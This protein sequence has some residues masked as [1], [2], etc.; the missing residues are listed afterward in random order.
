MIFARLLEVEAKLNGK[1][2][3]LDWLEILLVFSRE[4]I[5]CLLHIASLMFTCYTVC[6][7]ID[8]LLRRFRSVSCELTLC[9]TNFCWML[10]WSSSNNSW[11]DA[12]PVIFS[13]A[14]QVLFHILTDWHAHIKKSYSI[15]SSYANIHNFIL[16]KYTMG[17]YCCLIFLPYHWSYVCDLS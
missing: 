11:C 1:A 9:S 5:I 14:D 8:W 12:L 16:C 17:W 10:Y 13:L 7:I 15:I 6:M 3:I 4:Y 2:S